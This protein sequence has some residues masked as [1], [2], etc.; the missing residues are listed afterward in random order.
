MDSCVSYGGNI[1][2]ILS[3]QILDDLQT[4]FSAQ[5]SVL[6]FENIGRKDNYIL[7]DPNNVDWAQ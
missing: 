6:V 7:G 3:R 4:A 1:A 5:V 2:S